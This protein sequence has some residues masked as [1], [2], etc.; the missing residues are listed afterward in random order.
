[1][2]RLISA[3]MTVAIIFFALA[4]VQGQKLKLRNGYEYFAQDGAIG[5]RYSTGLKGPVLEPEYEYVFPYGGNFVGVKEGD[6]Y[7]TLGGDFVLQGPFDRI[8]FSSKNLVCATR[9]GRALIIINWG[10]GDIE[11]TETDFKTCYPVDD[12]YHKLFAVERTDGKKS[13]F[14][15]ETGKVILPFVDGGYH[16][17]WSEELSAYAEISNFD[18]V[19]YFMTGNTLIKVIEKLDSI[20]SFKIIKYKRS[21]SIVKLLSRKQ[22]MITK[23]NGKFGLTSIHGKVLVSHS[24]YAFSCKKNVIF[25][26]AKEAPTLIFKI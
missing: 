4:T 6:F 19:S 10:D 23:K 26:F 24:F 13:L 16:H 1:M 14:C 22:I 18:G 7:I 12:P 21:F 8:L 2:K 20:A 25:F 15:K 3:I 5:V 17:I 11:I 9:N